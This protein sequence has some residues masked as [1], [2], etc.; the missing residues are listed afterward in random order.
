LFSSPR[1]SS[2]ARVRGSANRAALRR[3]PSL[4]S[5][6]IAADNA[7]MEAEPS[8]AD[9]PKR[10]RR[11]LQFSLRTLLIFTLICGIGFARLGRKIER[12]RG[13]RVV[14][15]EIRQAGGRVDYDYEIALP[16]VEPFGPAWLR[17]LL[18]E[19]F[20]SDVALVVIPD[21]AAGSHIPENLIKLT[22]LER[23][24][25][26]GLDVA[27]GDLVSLK[28][29]TDLRFLILKR[30]KVTDTGLVNLK[31]LTRLEFLRLSNTEV[32]DAG[33]EELRK[34]L[35]NCVIHCDHELI[36]PGVDVQVRQ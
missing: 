4:Q 32:T 13:E 8:K 33:I 9:Q 19:D 23:L 10:K 14:V 25:L 36:G 7:A 5:P 18:G 20:F 16:A 22:R 3:R 11:W 15:K 35:P 21:A 30:S 1:Q 27:D 28:G 34:A 2:R 6:V 12:K 29:L 31:N 24:C 17:E 26:C